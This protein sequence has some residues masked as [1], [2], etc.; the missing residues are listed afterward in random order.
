MADIVTPMIKLANGAEMPQVGLGL[1]KMD[2]DT[3]A[4]V[5]Y[6]A[7]KDGYRLFDGACDYGNEK[8]AGN[9]VT[10]AIKDG[11]V[12]RSELFI[13]SKL[14][15]SFHD[16]ERVEPIVRK[17]LQDWGVDYFDL[18]YI[19][20]PV[21][22]Q[23]VDPSV[24]YPPGWFVDDAG[25][26]VALGK[27]TL[28]NTWEAMEALVPAGL[29]KNI[30]VSNYTGALLLDLLTYAK[31]RPAVLQIEHHP[32]L[33]QQPLLD[34]CKSEGIAVT[35]YSSFGPQS[36]R[37]LGMPIADEIT[38]L[39]DHDVIT[40][41]AN[42]HRK[43]A[44]QVLLRWNTQQGIAVIPKSNTQDRLLENLDVT[45]FVLSEKEVKAITAL[46]RG[47]RFN[48]PLNY[49]IPVYNFS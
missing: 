4:D 38:L 49:G 14:W 15:N 40:K 6:R 23:Y 44:A 42:R 30:G 2:N 11:L 17:Q 20:F 18:Y 33:V 19:H 26:K 1:W 5:V 7:I 9:G 45:S 47:F 41:I 39:F 36:F 21:S 28:Q 3:C 27:A 24:R 16:P 31:I 25:T 13:I 37:D 12:K 48:D 8:E 46:D 32:Y 22:L 43:T 34:F 35:G 29:A 10:R